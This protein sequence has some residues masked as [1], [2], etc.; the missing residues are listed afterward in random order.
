MQTWLQKK[1]EKKKRK[2]RK[3]KKFF[4]SIIVCALEAFEVKQREVIRI[5]HHKLRMMPNQNRPVFPYHRRRASNPFNYP[6]GFRRRILVSFPRTYF[7]VEDIRPGEDELPDNTY[8][9][10][11]T[12]DGGLRLPPVLN[13][14]ILQYLSEEED[15]VYCNMCLER[16]DI[17]ILTIP[18]VLNRKILQYLPGKDL[19]KF[20]KASKKALLSV[21]FS[22]ALM[23]DAIHKRIEDL[24]S[25]QGWT[26]TPGPNEHKYRVGNC[27][28]F[29]NLE[30]GYVVHAT[31]KLVFYVTET[32][33]FK[34]QP[35]VRRVSNDEV[36][37]MR[38]YFQS[39][40]MEF[41]KNWRTW[42]SLTREFPY[43][44]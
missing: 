7:E 13:R 15:L 11:E 12:P 40:P 3:R 38:P 10:F 23:F 28:R 43:R 39:E 36:K 24:R 31:P 1:E 9:I 20:S 30:N 6:P 17:S 22:H 32:N 26:Q 14:K 18:P 25:K 21:E 34:S 19:L 42:A 33:I 41:V 5:R 4:Q 16:N 29:R 8:D 27:V 35:Q 2:K 37:P 44:N